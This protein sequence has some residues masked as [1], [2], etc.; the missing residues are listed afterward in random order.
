MNALTV[1]SACEGMFCRYQ[2]HSCKIGCFQLV[3][4]WQVINVVSRFLWNQFT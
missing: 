2:P 4:D 3:A 1:W